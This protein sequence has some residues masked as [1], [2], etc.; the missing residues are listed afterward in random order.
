MAD[1]VIAVVGS[2]QTPPLV[3]IRMLQRVLDYASEMLPDDRLFVRSG[4]AVGA[5]QVANLLHGQLQGRIQTLLYLPY[6]DFNTELRKNIPAR[7]VRCVEDMDERLL[8]FHRAMVKAH[9]PYFRG[10]STF[11]L[12]AHMRNSMIVFGEKHDRPVLRVFC[13]TRG[14]EAVGGT[15]MAIRMANA[16]K[17]PVENLW[18]KGD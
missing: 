17:I 2:R 5:D 16:A 8:G 15:G 14:G 13:W 10:L 3:Q 9:H 4:N 7:H 6:L 11:A 1:M 18:R 12:K